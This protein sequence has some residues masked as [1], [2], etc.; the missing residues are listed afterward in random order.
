MTAIHQTDILFDDFS[1]LAQVLGKNEV[2]RSSPAI[3]CDCTSYPSATGHEEFDTDQITS[4][5]GQ[6]G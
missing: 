1:M 4:T 3:D 6:A 2:N 5:A